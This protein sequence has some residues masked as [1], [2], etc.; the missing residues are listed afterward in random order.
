MIKFFFFN[1]M[2]FYIII[3]SDHFLIKKFCLCVN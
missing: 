2:N 3:W 1:M